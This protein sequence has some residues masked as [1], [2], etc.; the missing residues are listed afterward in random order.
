MSDETTEHDDILS[1]ADQAAVE[2][3]INDISSERDL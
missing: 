2:A 1:A 3:D